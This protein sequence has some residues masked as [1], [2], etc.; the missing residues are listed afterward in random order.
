MPVLAERN[1]DRRMAH[2]R[3]DRLRTDELR[4]DSA[5][6]KD[7][8]HAVEKAVEQVMAAGE[9]PGKSSGGTSR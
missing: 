5:E 7:V 6:K 3:L 2:E 4:D 9:G 8:Q 1:L